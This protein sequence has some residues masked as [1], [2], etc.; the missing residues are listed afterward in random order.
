MKVN[1]TIDL[2]IG[3]DNNPSFSIMDNM[4]ELELE[5]EHNEKLQRKLIRYLTTLHSTIFEVVPT[6]TSSSSSRTARKPKPIRFP[7]PKG[8]KC[9]HDFAMVNFPQLVQEF[10]DKHGSTYGLNARRLAYKAYT[11]N[12][13]PLQ[14]GSE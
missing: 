10:V 7:A 6:S 9:W 5:L 2:E 11:L 8:Y 12:L 14:V 1:F 13:I 3:D 4:H